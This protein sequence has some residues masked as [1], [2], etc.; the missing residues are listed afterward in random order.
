MGL[1]QPK[2]RDAKGVVRKS[3]TWWARYGARGTLVRESTQTTDHQEAHRFL[4]GG[5]PQS[6]CPRRWRRADTCES[7]SIHRSSVRRRRRTS[8]RGT[9]LR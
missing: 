7:R 1:Y 9:A 5:K 4:K 8:A 2:Y 3:P 6:S